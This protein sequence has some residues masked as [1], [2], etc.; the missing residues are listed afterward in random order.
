MLTKNKFIKSVL[1]TFVV[2]TSMSYAETTTWDFATGSANYDVDNSGNAFGN[3]L[4]IDS[5]NDGTA[6]LTIQALADTGCGW[7]C[8]PDD[9]VQ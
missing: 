1:L 6:E 3:T 8:D 9:Q 5:D 4:S 7:N 2:S